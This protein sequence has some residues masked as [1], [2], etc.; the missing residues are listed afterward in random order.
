M[1][2]PRNIPNRKGNVMWRGDTPVYCDTRRK[3]QSRMG[4]GRVE[5]GLN[6]IA[7][8]L[9]THREMAY[10]ETTR[11]ATLIASDSL[12]SVHYGSGRWHRNCLSLAERACSRSGSE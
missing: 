10:E 9:V 4:M 6:W 7:T 3:K 1:L 12:K 5:V 2:E 11:T 8:L